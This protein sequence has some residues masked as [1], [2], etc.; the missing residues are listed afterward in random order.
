MEA[1]QEYY[2]TL[3]ERLRHM[4]EETEWLEYKMNNEDPQ[5]I[6]EYISALS[7][8]AT[9]CNREKAYIIWGIDDISHEIKG[10]KFSLKHAKVGNQELEN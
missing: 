10:T 7:N 6:G 5:M 8:S 9:I 2:R 3:V 1:E 4:S